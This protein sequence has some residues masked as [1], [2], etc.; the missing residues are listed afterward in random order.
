MV[1]DLLNRFAEVGSNKVI[2]LIM[3]N[4]LVATFNEL[5]PAQQLLK[6]FKNA[7]VPAEIL[8]E[9]K[10][11]RFWFMCEPF[12]A[13]HVEVDEQDYLKARQLM[14]EWDTHPGILSEA[15]RCPDCQSC[16]VEYPQIT[17]KFITPILSRLFMTFRLIPKEF[18]CL[19]CQYTWPTSVQI[20]RQRDLFG[21][22]ADTKSLHEER[23]Q[24]SKPKV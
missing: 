20:E 19:D 5:E 16:R 17:R 3:N 11:E 24:A 23:Y 6:Q 1:W 21:W 15:V 22:S 13:F 8:D 14:K 18:Y 12:A 2:T 7:K 10:I 4:I 9:T